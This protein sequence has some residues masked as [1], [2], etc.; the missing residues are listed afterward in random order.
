MAKEFA[1]T[2]TPFWKIEAKQ[3][4]IAFMILDTVNNSTV[5]FQQFYDLFRYV[6]AFN[7][8]QNN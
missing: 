5:K 4:V 3:R 1:K 7:I 8:L 2:L 6:E